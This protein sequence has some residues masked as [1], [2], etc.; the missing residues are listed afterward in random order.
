MLDAGVN[1]FYSAGLGWSEYDEDTPR[2]IFK[3][4]ELKDQSNINNIAFLGNNFCNWYVKHQ[5]RS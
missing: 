4:W 5:V 3:K 1:E 2:L